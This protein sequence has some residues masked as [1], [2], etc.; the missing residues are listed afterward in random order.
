MSALAFLRQPDAYRLYLI[1]SGAT[2]FLFALAYTVV[3]VYRVERAGLGPLQ[4]VLVG[5]TLEVTYFL[6]NVPTGVVA[7][8]YSRR[9]SVVIGVFL[10]GAGLAVEGAF[11]LFAAILLAQVIGGVGYTFVEGA[12][13]AWL[14]DEVGEERLGAALLRGGQ[15]GGVAGF[16]GIGASV[17]L[18]SVRLNLPV[19]VAAGLFVGLGFFLARTM[20][21]PAFVRP[22]REA[23]AGR[24]GR[25]TR[26]LGEMAATTR[27]GA[28]VVRRRPLALTILAVAAIFGGFGEGFDRLWEAHFLLEI[29]LPGLGALDPVVW[30]GVIEA[31]AALLGIGAAEVLRR[32]GGIERPA[33]AVRLLRGLQA[34]LMAAVVLFALAGGFALAVG[35]YW[36]ATVARGLVSPLYTAW[37]NRGVEPRVRATV[38]SLSGQADALGQFTVGPGIGA[39]GSLFGLRAALTVAGLALAPPVLLYGRAVGRVAEQS[40]AECGAEP[41]AETIG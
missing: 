10:L 3:A 6:F 18:A 9:L 14:S 37:I 40:S 4:L 34:T 16:V 7:D 19:L 24:R 20:R 31:G 29:G 28:A 41:P 1:Y 22:S 38:L 39:V 21:E 27:T 36:L 15:V 8:T 12:L 35:A 25:V 33:T 2:A 30:F 26:A 11:P 23:A 17:G 32:R 13:E 5:T